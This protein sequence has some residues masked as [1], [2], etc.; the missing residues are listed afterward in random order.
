MT[1]LNETTHKINVTR[2]D[3][4]EIGD[5]SAMSTYSS[6]GLARQKKQ[7]VSCEFK[8]LSDS[9]KN[10]KFDD[11]MHSDFAK[12]IIHFFIHTIC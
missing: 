8:S 4:F 5:T 3:T 2:N 10:P 1:E 9:L 11:G 12:V 7:P 6:G